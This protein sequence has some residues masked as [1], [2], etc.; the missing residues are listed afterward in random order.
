MQKILYD[1]MLS[2]IKKEII[3][4][5]E[6]IKKLEEIDNKYSKNKIQLENI[7]KIVEYY[8]TKE[9]ENLNEELYVYCNG[10]TYIVLNLAMIA[11][12]KNIS[13]KINID[14]NMLGVNK[15]II[16]IINKILKEN[17]INIKIEITEKLNNSEK[18][19][20]IDR[21]ND[22]NI[23]K[24]KNKKHIPYESIDIYSEEN[25]YEELFEKI[26]EYAIDMNIDIDIFDDEGIESML[27]YG[28][29]K[30]KLILTKDKNII[31]RY[32]EKNIY[33]NEN[34]FK[35]EKIIF[36]ENMINEIIRNV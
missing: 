24:N 32:K 5:K 7:T 36:D 33:I 26:Y 27:K 22:F 17:R 25:E 14:D 28:K 34:P 21:I 18:I 2:R 15:L 35:Q 10:N 30:N 6:E 8:K 16:E 9:I 4:N 13:M 20:F 12:I 11:I 1:A 19:I 31:E 29:G 3:S 23:I